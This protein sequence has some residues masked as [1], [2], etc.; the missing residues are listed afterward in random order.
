MPTSPPASERS[1][2]FTL[3]EMLVTLVIMAL[4]AGLATLSAGGNAQRAARDE[5][6]R[7]REVLLYARDEATM[8]GDELGLLVEEDAYRMLRFDPEAQTWAEVTEKPL[9]QHRLPGGMSLALSLPGTPARAGS[10]EEPVPEVLLSSSGEI[11]EFRLE[12]RLSS[13]DDPVAGLESDGSGTLRD[14]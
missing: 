3:V 7:I 13:A 14:L 1:A 11:G 12:L 4:L 10:G 9:E 6:A 8:Q 2:G 5:M